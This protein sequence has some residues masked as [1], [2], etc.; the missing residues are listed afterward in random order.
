MQELTRIRNERGWSQ[1]RLSDESGVNKATINQIERGRRSPNL[2]TLEKLADALNVGVGDFFPKAQASLWS[3]KPM[4]SQER[5]ESKLPEVA[6]L[7]LRF[8]EMLLRTWEAELPERARAGDDEWLANTAVLWRAFGL[9]NYGVL[10][11]LGPDGL[12]GLEG[13]FARYMDVNAAVHRINA[14]VREN[15]VPGKAPDEEATVT[16]EPLE[17]T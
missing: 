13:W 5:R 3:E 12:R 14:K 7:L 6:D 2:E 17:V 16:L 8:G 9:I 15:S 4:R 11:E 10:K 1:Q